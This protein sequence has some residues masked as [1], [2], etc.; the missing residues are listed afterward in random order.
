VRF[1]FY[2]D[3]PLAAQYLNPLRDALEEAFPDVE[4]F[5]AGH[6]AALVPYPYDYVFTCDEQSAAPVCG[7]RLCVFHGLASKGQAFSTIRRSAFVDS[8]M[9]F[10]VPGPYYRDLLLRMGVPETRI[11]VA[12]LTKLSGVQRNILYAPTHNAWLSAIPVVRE[13]IYELPNVRVQLHMW[14]E[15]G[16]KD[17]QKLF[18]SYYPE[19][20]THNNSVDNL[21][22][23]DTVIGDFGSIIV[24]AIAL[25]KQ[26]I[27]V[28]NPEWERFYL[29]KGLSRSEITR[30]P[31]VYYPNKYAIQ[32]HSM[33]EI[34][35]VSN[36]ILEGDSIGRVVKW[37]EDNSGG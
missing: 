36:I 37:V 14:T 20:D 28:V 5:E 7:K 19:L 13:R 4:M 3:W 8:D 31:E 6:H 27:Q 10:A 26:A 18:R 23:A 24:E 22:W 11:L 29:R 16:K 9:T 33:D 34:L 25:G 30:L 21:K 32:V 35:K 15:T 17:K 1:L 2:H 12:G